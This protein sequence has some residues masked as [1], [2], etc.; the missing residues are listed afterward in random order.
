VDS[1][2]LRSISD[3][4]RLARILATV[5]RFGEVVGL[6]GDLGAGKTTLVRCLV[7][8]LNGSERHVASPSFAL[9]H[10]Y[11]VAVDKIPSR[12]V[13][14]WDLYRVREAPDE[15]HEPP[16][17]NTLRLI[18]WPER[19]SLVMQQLQLLVHMTVEETGQRVVRFSGLRGDEVRALQFSVLS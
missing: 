15:L 9:Q 7:V 3:T 18:E 11:P 1:I 8:A 5:L 13:E 6:Q 14:H 2:I 19:S 10:E 4:A 12:K 17:T 16:D